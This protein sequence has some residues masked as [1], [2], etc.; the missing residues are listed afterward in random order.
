MNHSITPPPELLDKWDNLPMSTKE[1]FLIAV[2]WGADQELK[3]CVEWVKNQTYWA[4][5]DALRIAR[6]PKSQTLNSVAL[7][8]LKTIE[9]D[10]HYIP[11][12]TETIRCALEAMPNE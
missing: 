1:I 2:Q 9:R 10:G 12:I 7:Q 5:E 4:S 11:E 3:A 8:M 6:R